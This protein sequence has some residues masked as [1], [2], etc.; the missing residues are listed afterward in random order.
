M[1]VGGTSFVMS[2]S[3]YSLC[4]TDSDNHRYA[5]TVKATTISGIAIARRMKKRIILIVMI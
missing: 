3:V 4:K 1:Y 2:E 5:A